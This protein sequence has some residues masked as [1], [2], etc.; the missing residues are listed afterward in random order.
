MIPAT[1]SGVYQFGI[2]ALLV[3]LVTV[4]VLCSQ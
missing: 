1:A 3:I 4:A 2:H